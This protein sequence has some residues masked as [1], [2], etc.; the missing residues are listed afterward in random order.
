MDKTVVIVGAGPAGMVLAY[1][2]ALAGAEPVVLD[3]H[4]EQRQN[5]PGLA[6]NVTVVELLARRGLMEALN[7]EGVSFPIA[8]FSHLWLDPTKLSEHHPYTFGLIQARLEGCLIEALRARG[9]EIRWGH[10]VTGLRQD[11][12]TVTVEAE[13]ANGPVTVTGR[14]A[15][16]CDGADSAVRRLAGID[17]PGD[18]YRFYGITGDLLVPRGSNLFGLLGPDWHPAGAFS[19]VPAGKAG[20][21]GLAAMFSNNVTA[22]PD[23]VPMRV[24]VGEFEQD[25]PDPDAAPT[26]E[27]LHACALRIVGQ[28]LD[29]GEP[30]WLSRWGYSRRQATAYRAGRVFVAGDAAHVHF[31]LGGQALSTGVEDAVNLGWKLAAVLR[32]TAPES[33][34]DTYHTERHPVGESACRTTQAQ[35]SLL[36]PWERALPLREI[37]QDLIAFPDVNEYLLKMAA[38]L[39]IRYP[40]TYPDQPEESVHPLQGWRLPAIP[41]EAVSGPTDL[42][43]LQH[44]GGGLLLDMSGDALGDTVAVGWSDRVR[45]VRAKTTPEVDAAVVLLRPDGRVAWADRS[46]TDAEGLARALSTWFGPAHDGTEAE[47]RTT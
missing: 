42:A 24:L 8:H 15:V 23:Q 4:R 43:R 10:R 7:G 6:L 35:V 1:E 2:L 36:Y 9:V 40:I 32:G 30:L 13:T 14:Y 31:P 16:G 27:E 25:A 41:V 28:D 12:E 45:T 34:L 3:L 5:A 33:L 22:V 38:A 44:E 19:A 21:Q 46:G 26:V 29:L 39:N 37:L 20:I 11:A 17:F 18:D 47:V